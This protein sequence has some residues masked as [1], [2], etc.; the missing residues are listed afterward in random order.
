MSAPHPFSLSDDAVSFRFR[1]MD[2]LWRTPVLNAQ[3]LIHCVSQSLLLLLLFFSA[4]HC[5]IQGWLFRPEVFLIFYITAF[6][7]APRAK[8]LI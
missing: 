4:K 7:H 5:L 3:F 8:V 1:L 6:F 2:E